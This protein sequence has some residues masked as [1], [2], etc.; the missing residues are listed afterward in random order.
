VSFPGADVNTITWEDIVPFTRKP[1][2][3][4]VE[5][6]NSGSYKVCKINILNDFSHRK[7]NMEYHWFACYQVCMRYHCNFKTQ[8]KQE[9]C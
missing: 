4:I 1:F 8:Q 2:F 6:D 3:L 7:T 5:S 9:V